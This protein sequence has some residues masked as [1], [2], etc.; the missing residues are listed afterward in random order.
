MA[1]ELLRMAAGAR[2]NRIGP[3]AQITTGTV[4]LELS[5]IRPPDG[6][7]HYLARRIR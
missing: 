3:R 4:M 7:Y 6:T 5:Q 2:E 1:G